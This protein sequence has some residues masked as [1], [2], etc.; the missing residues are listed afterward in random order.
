[1]N[2]LPMLGISGLT[3][4]LPVTMLA[5]DAGTPRISE[6]PSRERAGAHPYPGRDPLPRIRDLRGV[7]RRPGIPFSGVFAGRGSLKPRFFMP[8]QSQLK[9]PTNAGTIRARA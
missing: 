1:M 8:C 9:K 6:R 2:C 5:A 7:T 4:L 3:T